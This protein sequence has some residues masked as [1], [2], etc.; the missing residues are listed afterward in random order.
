MKFTAYRE[1]AIDY[2]GTKI[3]EFKKEFDSPF[4]PVSGLSQ[5]C[6]VIYKGF[7]GKY[8]I[9]ECIVC[10]IWFTN[11]WGWCM[12]NGWHITSDELGK[13]I[14]KHDELQK[15]IEICEKKNRMRKVKVKYTI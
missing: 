1:A 13:T 10:E 2:D 12:D 15:A 3:K 8:K 7:F 9:R 14:F 4:I 6:Y 11:I 5:Y